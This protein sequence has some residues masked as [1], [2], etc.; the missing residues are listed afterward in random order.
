MQIRVYLSQVSDLNGILFFD[1]PKGLTSAS[2]V[3]RL[4]Y[5]LKASKVGHGG[6]LDPMATGILPIL[7]GEATK[8]A[9]VALESD[10]SYFAEIFLGII[11]DTGDAEGNL[12]K[13][14]KVKCSNEDIRWVVESL[15]GEQLQIPPMYSALKY[16]GTPLYKLARKGV[17]IARKPRKIIIKKVLIK[18][19][20]LPK[21]SIEI[22][23]SKG[24]YIRSVAEKIGNQLGCGAHLSK[25][26]RIAIGN[27]SKGDTWTFNQIKK[28]F[29]ELSKT[30]FL[31]QI[32]RP[33]DALLDNFDFVYLNNLEEEKFLNGQKI[34]LNK[35]HKKDISY[36]EFYP[37]LKVYGYRKNFLGLG[38]I[39]G[40]SHIQP[41]RVLKSVD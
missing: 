10:K 27:F 35:N 14:V 23:C 29:S 26:D 33:V 24:T 31:N 5:F 22:V 1:K 17:E 41:V 37:K 12:L 39:S 25:L 13:K 20:N 8:F 18:E 32:F 36:R 28:N 40:D 6:T 38:M 11:T 15:V 19:I 7:F 16:N 2:A 21:I 3:S 34:R 9:G 30:E 4:K